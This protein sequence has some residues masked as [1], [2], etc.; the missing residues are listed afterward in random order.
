MSGGGSRLP[1]AS[2]QGAGLFVPVVVDHA[3][4]VKPHEGPAGPH[5]QTVV[6]LGV[7]REALGFHQLAT[8]LCQVNQ[9][10]RVFAV[11]P[12]V[13]LAVREDTVRGLEA[14]P[15]CGRQGRSQGLVRQRDWAGL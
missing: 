12:K 11:L 3:N 1:G 8:V 4:V 6:V 13:I 14:G 5:R 9:H 15:L 7:D 2:L 10:F